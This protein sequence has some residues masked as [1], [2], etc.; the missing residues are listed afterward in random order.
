MIKFNNRIHCDYKVLPTK[1]SPMDT[2]DS[3]CDMIPL[4]LDQPDYVEVTAKFHKTMAVALHS[5]KNVYR[6]QNLKVW[7]LFER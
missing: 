2:T 6:I 3:R 5:I 4:K 1:W 7:R